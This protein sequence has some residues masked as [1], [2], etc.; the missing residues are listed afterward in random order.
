[1][2]PV[3]SEIEALRDE[4]ELNI[5]VEGVIPLIDPLVQFSVPLIVDG[6]D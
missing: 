1:M 3:S 4:L 6:V 5:V 2:A